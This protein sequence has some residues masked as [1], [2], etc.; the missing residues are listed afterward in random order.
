MADI[1]TT[2]ELAKAQQPLLLAVVTFADGSLLRLSTHALNTAEGGYAYAGNSYTGRITS[3]NLGAFQGYDTS[4]IDIIPTASITIADADKSIK[5]NYEDAKGFAGATLELVFIFWDAGTATFSSDS[6][7]KFSGICDG[8]ECEFE[9][10][11]VNASNLLNLQRKQLP[12][13]L[14]QR[15]CPWLNP[16]TTA[17]RAT[18][19]D[20]DSPYF[21]CGETN[22]AAT[23]CSYTKAT[24]TRLTRFGGV[25]WDSQS[26]QYN[27]RDYVTGNVSITNAPNDLRYGEPV[28]M[29]YGTAWVNPKITNV[30]GDG[31]STRG[32]AVV[33]LGEVNAILRVVVNDTE[34]PPATDITGATNY[35]VRDKLLRYNVINRGGRTGAP[36]LDV[37]WN[38]Q[39]DPYG[40]MCAI[41]WCVPRRVAESS[42][43]PRMRVLV[44]GP[45]IRVYTGV[46]TYSDA[47]TDNPAWVLMDLLV[48]A[49]RSYSELDIQSFIDAA[50][51]CSASV[52]YTDQY[53]ATASH[54][55]YAVS[56]VI[57]KRRSAAEV[58]RSVR[59]GC[60]GILVPNSDSGKIQLF[61]EG[62]LASQQPA[63]LSGSNAS[64][65]VTSKTLAGAV[66]NGY[67]AYSFT[68]VLMQGKKSTLT[69]KPRPVS[70]TPNR[71]QF[72]FSNSERDYAEDSISLLD[73]NAVF[74]AGGENTET[75]QA[76]GVST[77]D[78]AKRVASRRRR[79]NLYG[80]PRGDAGGTEIFEWLDTMRCIRLRVGHICV[81]TDPHYSYTSVPVRI[82][83]I[84]PSSNFETV[85]IVAER[86]NDNWFLDTEG[87]NGDVTLTQLARDR[88]ARAA[89]PWGPLGAQASYGD[90]MF[91]ADDWTF[92]L[93]ENA[94]TLAD[95]SSVTKLE[96]R[97]RQPVNLFSNIGPPQVGRQGTTSGASGNFPGS[98]WTYYAAIASKDSTGKLSALSLLCETTITNPTSVNDLTIPVLGWPTGAVGYVIYVGNT[99][100]LMTKHGESSTTPSSI[101]VTAWKERHGGAPDPEFDKM[102]LKMK[103]I[104]HSGIWGQAVASVASGVVVVAGGMTVN[105]YVGYNCSVL[106]LI[107]GGYMPLLNFTVTANA[108]DTLSLTPNPLTF[109]VV[110]GDAL[111]LRSLPAVGSD[112]TGNYV[113]DALW[114]NSV[115]GAGLVVNGEVGRLLRFICG[116][117]RGDIY[118]IK[119]NTATR[120]YVEGEWLATPGSTSRYIIEE[121]DWQVIQTS[122]SLN[123]SD[124]A[125]DFVSTIEVANYQR[126]TLLVQAFTLDGGE[127]ESFDNLSP[128]REIYV[129]GQGLNSAIAAS[130]GYA[131]M[132]ITA[133][134]VTPDLNNGLNQKVTLTANLIVNAPINTGGTIDAG[135]YL[136]LKF[137]QDATGGWSVT[138]N[139]IYKGMANEQ[140]SPNPSTYSKFQMTF[141]RTYWELDF[142]KVDLS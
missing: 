60:G 6:I 83:Q 138:W 47:Y 82:L 79:R 13:V 141:D 55:R 42:T 37:P 8:G 70:S 102:R 31:N 52:S 64:G 49:G 29:V 85:K 10:I 136:N 122:D 93:R 16:V 71:I 72:K 23:P 100:Q 81:L 4:G 87:Q 127:A 61:I 9:T 28:P 124:Q 44:Q 7:L 46:S 3:F 131:T 14:I 45:K 126:Q 112:G 53:G 21:R 48:E 36:N 135:V 92:A 98:G 43:R 54:A 95:G 132:T 12:N 121:P 111:I 96:I 103:R 59:M 50:A 110:A 65:A 128:C 11:T 56:L 51:I 17:Q 66:A 30:F 101:T 119:A 123:N 90:P 108:V 109:G 68:R 77:M 142:S 58:I 19:D 88:L 133:G 35:I 118:R 41:L 80:N 38:G 139:A 99:P 73:P 18:A 104:V 15:R 63:V 125:A 116:P 130:D 74:R 67:Y 84:R 22:N 32:E 34:L 33:A 26:G 40:S 115:S 39:G 94:E 1:N 134:A 2:K 69:G 137:I 76:E 78:Q 89:Y 140:P 106:G 107:G 117:G 75:F 114:A 105:Q 20:P 5:I 129:Y 113:D 27:S 25:N 86:H 57:D 91:T 24:C 62:T 120:I 97:G